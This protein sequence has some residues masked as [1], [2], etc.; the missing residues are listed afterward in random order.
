M[1]LKS[2]DTNPKVMFT[3]EVK[4]VAGIFIGTSTCLSL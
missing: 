2:D 4:M 1:E 3:V